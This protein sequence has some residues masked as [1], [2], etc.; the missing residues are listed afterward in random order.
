MTKDKL[1]KEIKKKFGTYSRFAKL[2]GL[3][4]YLLKKD[5]LDNPKPDLSDLVI[6]EAR[7]NDTNAPDQFTTELRKSLQESINESGGVLMFCFTNKQFIPSTLFAILSGDIES[8]KRIT[9]TIKQLLDH[10]E[11]KH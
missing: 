8:Y 7:L 3:D 10:F 2:A 9:P 5:V 11:I 1:K 6:I 4:Y